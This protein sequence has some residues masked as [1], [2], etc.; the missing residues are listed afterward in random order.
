MEASPNAA[1]TA[2]AGIDQTVELGEAVIL[3]G[4]GSSDDSTASSELQY[5]WS[6]ADLPPGSA[7]TLSNANTSTP[8]F[9]ADVVG[10]YTVQLVVTDSVA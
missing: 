7:A 1:P 9:V 10:T 3:D 2:Y 5:D 4:S 8:T 6:F